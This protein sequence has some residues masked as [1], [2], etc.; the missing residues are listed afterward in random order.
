MLQDSA[1]FSG[2]S[3][4][5]LQK[6]K[7]FYQNTLGLAVTEQPNMGLTLEFRS[8]A[9]VFIYPK[10]NHQPA[11]FTVLNFPVKDIDEAVD[12]LTQKGVTFEQYGEPFP[13]DEKGIARSN[14]PTQGPSIAWFTDPAGNVLAVLQD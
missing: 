3:V 7:D 6:A 9:K 2:F 14:D 10:P 8:G 11:T 5:D 12:A 13:T 4:D 1:A